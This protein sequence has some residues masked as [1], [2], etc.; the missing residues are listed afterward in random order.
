MPQNPIQNVEIFDVWG[1]D[2][3]SPFPSSR[4]SRYILMAV[5]NVSKWFKAKAL[6]TN[7]ARVVCKFLKQL[8]SRFGTPGAI[9]SYR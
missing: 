7:E 8:F 9:I 4:G 3:M 5:D 6:P 2:F 1:I